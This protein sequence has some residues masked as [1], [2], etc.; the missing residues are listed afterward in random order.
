LRTVDRSFVEVPPILK[1]D[2]ARKAR[3]VIE[4]FLSRKE[5]ARAQRRPPIEP[6]LYNHQQV[7]DSLSQLFGGKCAFCESLCSEPSDVHHFRPSFGAKDKSGTI[8]HDH[9]SWLSYEWSNLYLACYDCSRL[10]GRYFPV[11]G[12]RAPVLFSADEVRTIESPLLLD[13]CFDRVY[14]HLA[15]GAS[16]KAYGKTALGLETIGAFD[17]N[18]E[19]LVKARAEHFESIFYL[20]PAYLADA[21][22]EQLQPTA[23]FSGAIELLARSIFNRIATDAGVPLNRSSATTEQASIL[24]ASLPDGKFVKLL[25]KQ[26]VNSDGAEVGQVPR[27]EAGFRIVSYNALYDFAPVSI[28]SIAI[29]NFKAIER[30]DFSFKERRTSGEGVPSIMLLGENATGKSSVLEAVAMA[31]LGTSSAQHVC[32]TPSGYIRRKDTLRWGIIDAEPASVEI[33][34]HDG[35]RAYFTIDPLTSEID[36]PKERAAIVLGYGPRRYF[37]KRHRAR[38]NNPEERVR[39]LFDP[40]ASITHPE[41]WLNRLASE[42]FDAVS[43]ALR[44]ILVLNVDDDLIR[45]PG[46]GVCVRAHGQL[47][48]IDRLSEGYKSLFAMTIDIMRELLLHWRDLEE[49]RG[50]VLIDEIETHLHPRWKMRVMSALRQSMPNV[51]FITT[52]HDPL[53]L[54]GM[55]DGEVQVLTRDSNQKIELLREL[56]NITGMRAEQL[57]TSDYFGLS[58]TADPEMDL[59]I[60]AYADAASGGDTSSHAKDVSGM[61]DDILNRLVIGDSAAEQVIQDALKQ[62]LIARRNGS[63]QARSAAR[64]AAVQDILRALGRG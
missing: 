11:R 32:G 7:R 52:T 12:N 54:R 60:A 55:E 51:T 56:P 62:Y 17:L 41:P 24:V 23:Q 37:S 36:G 8:S 33:S 19:K 38:T 28:R 39:T 58:S 3:S 1:S 4:H 21:L 10:K 18:R 25:R 61:R 44:E 59:A 47:T 30:L 46:L 49:A 34:F 26:L 63:A 57:L 14:R 42:K 48:P 6:S 29:Q 40:L 13:P 64:K 27:L 9:Y 50:V 43:R 2:R 35:K 45:D 16:G 15:F 22:K 5:K 53:C 31:L 20:T